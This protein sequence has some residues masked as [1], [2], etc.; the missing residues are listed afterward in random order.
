MGIGT[1]FGPLLHS[2]AALYVR[3]I[4]P[5]SMIAN[6]GSVSLGFG[7]DLGSVER[8]L[9][10]AVQAS[11]RAV[12][13]ACAAASA[14]NCAAECMSLTQSWPTRLAQL[15]LSDFPI[16]LCGRSKAKEQPARAGGIAEALG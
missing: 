2:E 3:L 4:P 13:L 10:M 15:P 16:S 6:P 9:L 14:S 11:N 1:L 8:P 7:H 5:H 12:P